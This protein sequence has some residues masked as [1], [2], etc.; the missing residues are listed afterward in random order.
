MMRATQGLRCRNVFKHGRKVGI[1]E[2]LFVNDDKTE[3][4]WREV[5]LV[6]T[7]SPM[8]GT[9]LPPFADQNQEPSS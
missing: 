2:Q 7:D 8:K 4:E 9:G 5:P 6:P 3:W 1:V